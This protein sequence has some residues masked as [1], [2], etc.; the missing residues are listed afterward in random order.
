[1]PDMEIPAFLLRPKPGAQ[2]VT[3][4]PAPEPKTKTRRKDAY[5]ARVSISIP[6]DMSDA[7]SLAKAIEAVQGIKSAMPAGAQVEVTASLGKI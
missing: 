3:T 4:P 2:P 1:M 7:T 6:L 5:I